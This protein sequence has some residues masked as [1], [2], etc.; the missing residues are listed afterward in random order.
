MSELDFRDDESIRIPSILG[1]VCMGLAF[2]FVALAAVTGNYI[3][4]LGTGGALVLEVAI[5]G[6][7][8]YEMKKPKGDD[9]SV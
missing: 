6:F 7:I 3:A 5:I 4:L 9:K 8:R 1:L 2:F